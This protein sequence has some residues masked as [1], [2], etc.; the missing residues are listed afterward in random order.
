VFLLF[1][2]KNEANVFFLLLFLAALDTRLSMKNQ[3]RFIGSLTAARN[4]IA[5]YRE[6]VLDNRTKHQGHFDFCVLRPVL[7]SPAHGSMSPAMDQFQ[8]E[9]V[10]FV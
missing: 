3:V 7:R 5:G 10:W 1:L 4:S 6:L 9:V 2:Q 8:I